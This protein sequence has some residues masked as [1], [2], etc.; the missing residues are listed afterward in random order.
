M[1][2]LRW[3]LVVLG[4]ALLLLGLFVPTG[5]YDTLPGSV[6]GSAPPFRG[7][8]LLQ[9]TFVLEGAGL[10]WA[11]FRYHGETPRDSFAVPTDREQ[12]FSRAWDIDDRAAVIALVA[13]TALAL[14]LRLIAI[15]ADLWLDEIA[16]VAQYRDFS[17]LAVVTTYVSANNH[18]LNT[19][20]VKLVTSVAGEREW[21][22]RLPAVLFGVAT[23]P[24]MYW[25]ARL[26][27]SR[28]ASLG[29]ALLLAVSYHHVFFSQN[30]RGY[31]SYLFFSLLSTGLLV[32]AM[33][34]DRTREWV[35]YVLAMVFNFA[36]L[37]HGGF[38][39]AGHIV[40]GAAMALHQRR[41]GRSPR[42][43]VRRLA[44][45]FGITGF[46]GLQL[47]VTMMAQAYGVLSRT[48]ASPAS[49][50]SVTSRAFASD[51]IRGLAEGFGPGL[52]FGA[53]P[54]M[55]IAG[56]GF[57]VLVRRKWTLAAGL[58]MPLALLVGLVALRSLAASPRFFLLGLP[59]ADL[60]AVLG[61]F[62]VVEY[63]LRFGNR[64]RSPAV[65]SAIAGGMILLVALA[66]VM[67]L[68]A[69]YRTPK[70]AYRATLDYMRAENRPGEL[71]VLVQ[72]AE[73]GFRFYSERAHLIEGRDFVAL[74]TLP[75]LEKARA[76]GRSLVI[77]TTLERS[78]VLEQ[79]DLYSRI[80]EGWAPVRSFP[81]TI[82]GGEIRVWRARAAK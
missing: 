14:A 74:R 20:L 37:L 31:S 19:L 50:M 65:A 45:V 66:S 70:Q 10:L 26:V 15:N 11:A 30:A 8:L 68:P 1:T 71:I 57:I 39:F 43:L 46:L 3:G 13:I 63:A 75:A 72:N 28:V 73:Q 55:A 6:G 79:P 17:P 51:F 38:V 9:A 56:C 29:V 12:S 54:V 69:Y 22:I 78:L 77:V 48:Y 34:S 53:V 60:A 16:P 82:H 21:A 24:V 27:T 7:V 64:L 80:V 35:A 76:A 36:S 61:V 40:V 41:L 25:V 18:L 23:I 42:P 52:L 58:V 44:M 32:R 81:A 67:S 5:W 47:Y 59:L 33:E 62:A 49:G 2:P 4:I